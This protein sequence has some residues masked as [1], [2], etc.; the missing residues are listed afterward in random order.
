MWVHE[1]DD[2]IGTKFKGNKKAM[3]GLTLGLKKE[4]FELRLISSSYVVDIFMVYHLNDSF[5]WNGY[6][7]DRKLYQ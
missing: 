2:S 3:L 7:G 4:A 6:Q 1:Y 5:Q